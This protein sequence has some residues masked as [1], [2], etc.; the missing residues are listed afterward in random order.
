VTVIYLAVQVRQNT[1]ALRTA[2][3]QAV[4]TTYR[5]ANQLRCDPA[6]ASAW[7][8]GLTEFPDLPFEDRNYFSTI[9]IDEGLCF[10]GAYALYASGQLEEST[11]QAYLNW[12]ASLAATPGGNVWWISTGRPIFVPAMVVAVD[13][14]L[15]VG[16]LM[17]IR[18]APGLRLDE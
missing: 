14:R 6:T 11:Y 17:D 15:E 10:Q 7:S 16:N 5:E 18:K 9:M 13:A 3:W 1:S 2:S 8:K 4:V 12:F